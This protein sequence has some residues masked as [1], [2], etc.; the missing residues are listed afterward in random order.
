MDSQLKDK[1]GPKQRGQQD[2]VMIGP[3]HEFMIFMRVRS[4]CGSEGCK[5]CCFLMIVRGSDRDIEYKLAGS[6]NGDA[7]KGDP[8]L[9]DEKTS[10]ADDFAVWAKKAGAK[11]ATLTLGADG[12]VCVP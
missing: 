6:C 7:C 5:N 4:G 11:V 1:V 3:G 9:G 12:K 8:S 10:L 2:L